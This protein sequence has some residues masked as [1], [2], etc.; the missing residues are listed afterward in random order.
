MS[1]RRKFDEPKDFGLMVYAHNHPNVE[2]LLRKFKKR[3][4]ASG[5]I[6]EYKERQ[7]Y[8]KPSVKNRLKRKIAAYNA[9]KSS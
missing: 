9:K 8:T 4:Q 7:Y 1:K 6:E 2:V 3:V 5:V